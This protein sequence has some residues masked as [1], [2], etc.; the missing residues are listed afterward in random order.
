MVADITVPVIHAWLRYEF[1]EK[2]LTN[3]GRGQWCTKAGK[4]G[5]S[6]TH[7]HPKSLT[8]EYQS[9]TMQSDVLRHEKIYAF[10]S[11]EA[12]WAHYI[13]QAILRVSGFY[14]DQVFFLTIN[15]IYNLKTVK[16]R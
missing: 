1:P 2:I 16:V 13:P 3:R 15:T 4:G 10:P 9:D 14:H 8:R 7:S 6:H 11:A 12:V 5:K